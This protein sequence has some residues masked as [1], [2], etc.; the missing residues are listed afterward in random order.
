MKKVSNFFSSFDKFLK[1]KG[2]KEGLILSIEITH[3]IEIV[4]EIL[5]SHPEV[6]EEIT[7]HNKNHS[8]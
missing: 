2:L 3:E 7:L 6:L 4:T 5:C 1:T 8:V